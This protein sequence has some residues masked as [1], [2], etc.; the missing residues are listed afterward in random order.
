MQIEL[1]HRE[2]TL[3]LV[4]MIHRMD[5]IQKRPDLSETYEETRNLYK[6]IFSM[7]KEY[8]D[9]RNRDDNVARV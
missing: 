4:S 9:E 3:L 7:R 2:V 1:N 6:R 8:D 5:L